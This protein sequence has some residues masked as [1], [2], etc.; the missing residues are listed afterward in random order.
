MRFDNLWLWSKEREALHHD[1]LCM[2]DSVSSSKN[3][4]LHSRKG[5]KNARK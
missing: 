1:I 4:G 5:W 2:H 3:Q